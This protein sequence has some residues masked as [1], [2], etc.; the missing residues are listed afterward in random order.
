MMNEVMMFQA[1]AAFSPTSSSERAGGGRLMG[2][3]EGEGGKGR[4]AGDICVA[5]REGGREATSYEG[6]RWNGLRVCVR[7]TGDSARSQ[8]G[9]ES[10]EDRHMA[11]A[12]GHIAA[13]AAGCSK[14]PVEALGEIGDWA[15]RASVLGMEAPGGRAG[16]ARSTSSSAV[17]GAEATN[18]LFICMLSRARNAWGRST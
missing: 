17:A 1:F 7:E 2:A 5:E 13:G 16:T 8:R 9:M 15:S 14:L 12:D 3:G 11:P 6:W 18:G 4:S 10:W